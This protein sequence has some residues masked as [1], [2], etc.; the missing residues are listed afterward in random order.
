MTSKQEADKKYMGQNPMQEEMERTTDARL[1]S[2]HCSFLLVI[3]Q[4]SYCNG[5][6]SLVKTKNL[7]IAKTK[8]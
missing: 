2:D 1:S 8:S 6:K 3:L 5:V 7:D 4:H